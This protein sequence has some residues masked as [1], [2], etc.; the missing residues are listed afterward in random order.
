MKVEFSHKFIR[1][2][3][4]RFKGNPKIKDKL[5]ERTRLFEKN[6]NS[7]LLKNHP[8]K[9]TGKGYYAFSITGDIRVIYYVKDKIAYFVDIGTHN[10]VY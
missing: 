9:G 2:Y 7:P 8:L 1:I 6:P 4:I 5:Q 10:Q 3:K